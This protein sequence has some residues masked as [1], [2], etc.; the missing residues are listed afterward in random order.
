MKATAL[1][2]DDE[3]LARQR[4][5]DLLRGVGWIECVAEAEDGPTAIARI[6]ELRPDLAFIDIRMP[7][8]SGI[9]VLER[10]RHRP[11]VIFTTA[12]D[13]YAVTAFELQ[14]IDYLLKPFGAERF[15]RAV[16][17]AR[18]HLEL[19]RGAPDDGSARLPAGPDTGLDGSDVVSRARQAS[20]PLSRLFIRE[21]GAI[22]PVPVDTIERLEALDD[23]VA[24]YAGERR[25]LVGVRLRDFEARL[26][27]DRFVRVHRSHIVSLAHVVS[28]ERHDSTRLRVVLHSGAEIIASRAGTRRLRDLALC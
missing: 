13:Q 12:F 7:G 21:R 25:H 18:D 10:V 1:I 15:E 5:R 4:L 14:A 2:A 22:V 28:I 24:V 26:D 8:A 16:A 19:S 27:G 20:E 3:P 23:Y 6:D 9:E 17:R 11:Q